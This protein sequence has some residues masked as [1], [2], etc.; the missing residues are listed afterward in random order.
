MD[1]KRPDAGGDNGQYHSENEKPTVMQS[2]H[3]TDNSGQEKD[4]LPIHA[5]ESGQGI[6][7]NVRIRDPNDPI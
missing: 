4:S 1:S 6:N 3:G 2:E 5:D 7:D